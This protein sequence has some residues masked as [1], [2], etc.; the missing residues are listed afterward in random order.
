MWLG[1]QQRHLHEDG[2]GQVG[3]VTIGGE[4]AAVLLDSE[5]RGLDVYSPGGYRWV[6]KA[7]QKVLV[8]KGKGE[9][10]CVVGTRQGE[11]APETVTVE[12]S[13]GTLELSSE[14][15]QVEGGA[16]HLNGQVYVKGEPLELL[17]ARIAAGG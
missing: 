9:I 6:P 1:K 3:R 5:R 12:A 2:E 8:I 17:I 7:G 10:P 13:G 11:E 14:G 4:P 16:I 15:A